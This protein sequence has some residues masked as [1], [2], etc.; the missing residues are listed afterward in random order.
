MRKTQ[1]D[2]NAQKREQVRRRLKGGEARRT[3]EDGL[4]GAQQE[5]SHG[6]EARELGGRVGDHLQHSDK[7]VFGLI[8]KVKTDCHACRK[9][10]RKGQ[11]MRGR[12][13]KKKVAFCCLRT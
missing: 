9:G 2:A 6:L 5:V 7:V 12:E 1:S 13:L 10:G 11:R 8:V 3:F 4:G